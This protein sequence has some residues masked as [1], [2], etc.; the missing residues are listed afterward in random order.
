MKV[1]EKCRA[2]STTE[3][4]EK[5]KLAG[6]M[7]ARQALDKQTEQTAQSNPNFEKETANED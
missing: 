2:R 4:N 6:A 3:A 7:T 1:K 5:R